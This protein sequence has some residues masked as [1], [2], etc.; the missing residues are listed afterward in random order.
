MGLLV[1]VFSAAATL[2][3]GTGCVSDQ[4]WKDIAEN[5]TA[6]VASTILDLTVIDALEC[7]LTRECQ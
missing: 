2:F 3:A 4:T 1:A 5:S 6:T 7:A